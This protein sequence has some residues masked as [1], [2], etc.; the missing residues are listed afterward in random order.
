MNRLTNRL[1]IESQSHNRIYYPQTKS[2][3]T[4]EGFMKFVLRLFAIMLVM[5]SR[6]MVFP[7]NGFALAQNNPT[8]PVI[9]RAAQGLACKFDGIFAQCRTKTW[10]FEIRFLSQDE[11]KGILPLQ[12][13]SAKLLSIRPDQDIVVF[14][15]R[16]FNRSDK[17]IFLEPFSF[18]FWVGRDK[19]FVP[20]SFD[21]VYGAMGGQEFLSTEEGQWFQ[22]HVL[23]QTLY[24]P[25]R[26][27]TERYIIYRIPAFGCCRIHLEANPIWIGT[28]ALGFSLWAEPIQNRKR[29]QPPSERLKKSE[30]ATTDGEKKEES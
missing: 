8:I 16:W 12:K 2:S 6:P 17:P 29:F 24:V 10:G 9:W 27:Y 21:E 3:Q 4:K 11:I 14:F 26:S 19:S 5:V 1:R 15:T 25:P 20:V 13:V 22:K 30:K 18:V 28:E 23:L 7:Q